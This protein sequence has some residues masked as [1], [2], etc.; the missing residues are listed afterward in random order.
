MIFMTHQILKINIMVISG[1][2]K[3]IQ[4]WVC[5]KLSERNLILQLKGENTS[6]LV[7]NIKLNIELKMH[8]PGLAH[9]TTVLSS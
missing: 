6:M 5:M 8:A 9:R 4:W 3:Q 2:N 1:K 7:Y